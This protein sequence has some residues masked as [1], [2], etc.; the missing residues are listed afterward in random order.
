LLKSPRT[1]TLFSA[2]NQ[3]RSVGQDDQQWGKYL[4]LC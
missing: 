2:W 1:M 3:M 4:F